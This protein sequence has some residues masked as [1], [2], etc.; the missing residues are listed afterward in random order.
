MYR[1][2]SGR[3]Y[4]ES[5]TEFAENAMSKARVEEFAREDDLSGVDIKMARVAIFLFRRVSG[6]LRHNQT[7]P[8]WRRRRRTGLPD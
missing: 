3:V 2:P 4:D 6:G 8:T 7:L 5:M 1:W